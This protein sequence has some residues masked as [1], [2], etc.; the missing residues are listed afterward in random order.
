V[1]AAGAALG[2]SA[3]ATGTSRALS[4]AERAA[5]ADTLKGMV[6]AAYD[7][8]K[9]DFVAR[10]LRLYPDSGR[11]IS[12][13][14]GQ[15]A[16][17]RDTL[18]AGIKTFW[19]N[20]GSRMQSPTWN[21]GPMYVDVLSP[22]AAVLTTSYTVPHRTPDGQ[23]HTFAGAMTEV[24]ERRNGRWVIVQEHL[25]DLPAQLAEPMAPMQGMDHR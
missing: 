21:W 16:T 7:L 13:A 17:S 25:S 12:A 9:P 20:V 5:I 23:P 18:A 1:V 2:P 24:F 4:D 22:D 3:C 19:D 6:V 8:S 10:F 14:G 15:V 11:V